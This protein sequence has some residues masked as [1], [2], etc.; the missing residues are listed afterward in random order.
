MNSRNLYEFNSIH[1]FNAFGST[2]KKPRNLPRLVT[3]G[4]N[5]INVLAYSHTFPELSIRCAVEIH[6]KS[7]NDASIPSAETSIL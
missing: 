4:N 3:F 2:L 1:N 6:Q 5:Q 7:S